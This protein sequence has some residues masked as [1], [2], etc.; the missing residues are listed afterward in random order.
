MLVEQKIAALGR[1]A[2]NHN[3]VAWCLYAAGKHAEARQVAGGVL[4]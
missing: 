3:T 1:A 2:E 4:R